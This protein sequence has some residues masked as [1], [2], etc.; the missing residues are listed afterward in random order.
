MDRIDEKCNVHSHT[1]NH[2]YAQKWCEIDREMQS[3]PWAL[4][5][6]SRSQLKFTKLQLVVRFVITTD[7][8][9]MT[10]Q[11]IGLD[12]HIH[13][14]QTVINCKTSLSFNELAFGNCT[15]TFSLLRERDWEKMEILF[16]DAIQLMPNPLNYTWFIFNFIKFVLLKPIVCALN[17]LC[18]F[19]DS[20]HFHLVLGARFWFAIHYFYRFHSSSA[21]AAARSKCR[22]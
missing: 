13:I 17:R 1:A 10:I 5:K 11:L 12:L 21:S 18:L 7:G 6:Y 8:W 16:P 4:I 9:R 20:F 14:R 15:W 22:Y 19:F 3:L 2:I